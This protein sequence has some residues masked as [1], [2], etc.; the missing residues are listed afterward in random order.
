[1]FIRFMVDKQPS[2]I[3]SYYIHCHAISFFDKI[4]NHYYFKYLQGIAHNLSI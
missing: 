3:L 1:M 2:A 4:K